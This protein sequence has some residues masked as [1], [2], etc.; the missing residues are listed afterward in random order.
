VPPENI[1]VLGSN[2]LHPH[3]NIFWSSGPDYV[4]D[5]QNLSRKHRIYK[6]IVPCTITQRPRHYIWTKNQATRFAANTSHPSSDVSTWPTAHCYEHFVK[7][8]LASNSLHRASSWNR[9]PAT[10][11]EATN[12]CIHITPARILRAGIRY[13]VSTSSFTSLRGYLTPVQRGDNM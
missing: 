4:Y 10:S 3:I 7:L 9:D 11:F 8:R 12:C 5:L 13:F 2:Q 6:W 1:N